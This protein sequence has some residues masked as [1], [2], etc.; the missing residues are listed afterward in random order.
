MQN[1]GGVVVKHQMLSTGKVEAKSKE[2]LSFY[3]FR[4]MVM[5]LTTAI[6][7]RQWI[8]SAGAWSRHKPK[9]GLAS[10]SNKLPRA[11]VFNRGAYSALG[12]I[13]IS[14]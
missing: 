14:S 9:S 11:P 1:T 13:L 5:E 8:G 7:K 4:L 6:L 12:T 10:F 3:P 2:N